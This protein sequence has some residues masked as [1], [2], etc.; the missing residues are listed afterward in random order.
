MS[1]F[2][3]RISPETIPLGLVVQHLLAPSGDIGFWDK[4]AVEPGGGRD[5]ICRRRLASSL[6]TRIAR[7]FAEHPH[8]GVLVVD[9]DA[10]IT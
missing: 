1:W 9:V 7:L 5:W 2:E 3:A 6:P 8:F 10:K 4:M